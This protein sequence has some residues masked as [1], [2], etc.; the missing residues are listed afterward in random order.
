MQPVECRTCGATVTARKSSWDQTTVQWST[1]ALARC[2]ERRTTGAGS[3]RPNH[4]AF[5]G[6]AALRASI[7]D[8]AVRGTLE[9]QSSEPLKTNHEN[10]DPS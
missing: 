10:E 8:A 4:N 1:E 3:P 5:E 6:C 9:V 2:A 7:R